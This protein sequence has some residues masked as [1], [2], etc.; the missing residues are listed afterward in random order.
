MTSEQI[1]AAL[2]DEISR[3]QHAR[4]LIAQLSHPE[5][6]QPIGPE[7][8]IYDEEV[9]RPPKPQPRYL[10]TTILEQINEHLG[11]LKPS[12]K[13]KIL[14]LQESGMRISE[15]LQLPTDCLTQGCARRSL[16]EVHS[17]HGAWQSEHDNQISGCTRTLLRI[18]Y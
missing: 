17:H 12:W 14:I 2:D 1:V 5:R 10:P 16:P 13:R 7:R 15:L 8:M 11:D 9:P 18:V 3:L 4:T 6:W